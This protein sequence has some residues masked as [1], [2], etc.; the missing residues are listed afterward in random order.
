MGNRGE[1]HRTSIVLH[2]RQVGLLGLGSLALLDGEPD[3]N[4]LAVPLLHVHLVHHGLRGDSD[5]DCAARGTRPQTTDL[6]AQ[7]LGLQS[8]SQ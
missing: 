2:I 3:D 8:C 1:S 7:P 5:A 6:Q 4:G